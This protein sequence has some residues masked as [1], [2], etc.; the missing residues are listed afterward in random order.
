[1]VQISHPDQTFVVLH[2][3]FAGRT[4]RIAAWEHDRVLVHTR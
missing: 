3:L 2:Y 4:T 1:L